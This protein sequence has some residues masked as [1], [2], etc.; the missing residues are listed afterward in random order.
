[1]A[2]SVPWRN[3]IVD[4]GA[5]SPEHLLAKRI[6]HQV[7]YNCSQDD[8]E[9]LPVVPG[10]QGE[11]RVSAGIGAVPPLPQSKGWAQASRCTGWREALSV[12][13]DIED[14][15]GIYNPAS[16]QDLRRLEDLPGVRGAQTFSRLC[17]IESGLFGLLPRVQEPQLSRAILGPGDTET[18]T[19][20]E[21]GHEK[22]IT[23][24]RIAAARLSQPQAGRDAGRGAEGVWC[25]LQLLWRGGASVPD[26]GPCQRRRRV[27]PKSY[28]EVR[29]VA[30][31]LPLRVSRLV[32]RALLQLQCR[33]IPE[34][35]ALSA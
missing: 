24:I 3:R 2:K 8:D 19:R 33:A 27:L 6:S 25:L 11:I 29:Y 32:S 21:P 10:A 26:S 14:G 15:R 34:W 16:L 17:W 9:I 22:D 5:E 4:H 12:M 13:P 30:A 28:G 23:P 31:R 35:R 7:S 20:T 1:M 18:D